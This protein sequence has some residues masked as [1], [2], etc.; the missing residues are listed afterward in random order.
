MAKS[1]QLIL[2]TPAGNYQG[3]GETVFEALK[4]IPLEYT[5]V[6]SKGTIKVTKGEK[7]FKRLFPLL[8]LRRLFANKLYKEHW[9]YQVEKFIK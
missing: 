7:S 2:E 4:A 9:S 6:K 1:V 3:E 5:Q 8:P